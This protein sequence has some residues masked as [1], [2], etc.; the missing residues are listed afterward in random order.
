MT[1][2]GEK[3]NVVYDVQCT[4]EGNN[5]TANVAIRV[6]RLTVLSSLLL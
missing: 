5:S 4:V 3:T 6:S 1:V 2:L